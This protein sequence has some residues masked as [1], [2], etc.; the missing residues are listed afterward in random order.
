MDGEQKHEDD[1]AGFDQGLL[2]P[3][4]KALQSRFALDRQTKRQK[5]QR[6]KDRERKPCDPVHHRGDPQGAAAMFECAPD[7]GNTTAATARRPS[8][9]SASPKKTAQASMRRS[10]SGIHSLNTLRTPIAAWIET[11]RTNTP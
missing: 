6:Q 1:F 8:T 3:A 7:H 2:A 5:V 11:A 4:Q 10:S 9:A